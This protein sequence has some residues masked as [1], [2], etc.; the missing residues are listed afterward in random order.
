MAAKAASGLVRFLHKGH[1]W[2]LHT[3]YRSSSSRTIPPCT[4]FQDLHKHSPTMKLTHI[5]AL[6]TVAVADIIN[7][8]VPEALPM[9][10]LSAG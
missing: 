10:I 6:A 1:L 9:A 7:N 5:L 3:Q 2:H 8:E 4:Y